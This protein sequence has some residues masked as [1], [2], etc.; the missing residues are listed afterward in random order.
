[1]QAHGGTDSKIESSS[2]PGTIPANIRPPGKPE[3]EGA[4]GST[5]SLASAD[6][7]PVSGGLFSGLFSSSGDSAKSNDKSSSDSPG[8]LDRMSRM[9]GLRGSEP[10]TTP[11]PK[12]KAAKPAATQT[13][14]AGTASAGAIRPKPP[15]PAQPGDKTASA[16]KPAPSAPETPPPSQASSANNASLMNGAQAPLPSSFDSRWNTMR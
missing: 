9:V 14:S 8:V 12:P 6:S 1:V 11:T 2:L 7:R 16:S 3:P 15:A 4:T 10:D 13:A 5:M